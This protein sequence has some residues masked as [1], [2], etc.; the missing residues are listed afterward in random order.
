MNQDYT[1]LNSEIRYLKNKGIHVTKKRLSTFYVPNVIP[2]KKLIIE[3]EYIT[4]SIEQRFNFLGYEVISPYNLSPKELHCK[5]LNYG[6]Q[7]CNNRYK[8]RKFLS[9]NNIRFRYLRNFRRIPC[10]VDFYF[11]ERYKLC[12][13]LSYHEIL[14]KKEILEKRG[15]KY[16][17]FYS[18][19]WREAL[20]FIKNYS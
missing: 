7:E 4:P 18:D 9:C 8:L 20:E 19:N 2:E 13:D 12:I 16:K 3:I 17:W 5:I 14:N 11:L 10:Q 6:N 15:Y 1:K